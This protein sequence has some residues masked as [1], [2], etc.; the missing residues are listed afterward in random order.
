MGRLLDDLLDVSRITRG[1]LILRRSSVDLASAAAAAQESA[2]PLIE[3]RRH[4][5]VV[6]LREPIRLVADPVRL[7]QVLSNL[8]INAAKYT[9]TGGR[10][11]L[12][13][14][15]EGG[16]LVVAVRDNGIG[17]SAEMMPRVFT[18]FAQ[19]SPALE[20]S[21][22]GL[23]IGLAL[24]RGLV[25]L[26]GGSVS[27]HSGGVGQGSEFVVRLPLGS[28]SSARDEERGAPASEAAKPLRLLVADD[29]RD[30][31]STFAALLQASG[32]EVSV[33]HTGREAFDLAGK[34]QP[35]A[36]LLDIGMPELNG[37]Q[38][39]QRIRGTSWGRAVT[40]IAI[41][42]WGQEQDKRRALAAGFDQHLTKPIDPSHLEALLQ[43]EVRR[44]ET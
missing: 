17:I 18:L 11:E 41:T 21:E 16:E 35:D 28:P 23:G 34:L 26:H 5:L 8:L 1:T 42:G 27:A 3:A 12:E 36:L 33:A 38:L 4:T 44:H 6:K 15:R 32:H 43:R 37:Y 13:A 20:R 31:A 7:A 22:G 29:N 10:I 24:V 19:A 40:L 14:R 9:D 2:R 39:A 30:S 25:E